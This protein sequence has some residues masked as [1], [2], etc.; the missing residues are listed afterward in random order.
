MNKNKIVVCFLVMA[1]FIVTFGVVMAANPKI[2]AL[3]KACES[4][5]QKACDDLC[6]LAP[7]YCPTSGGSVSVVVILPEDNIGEYYIDEN[8]TRQYV[9]YKSWNECMN[10][11]GDA[12]KCGTIVTDACQSCLGTC[13]AAGS[14]ASC[15]AECKNSCKDNGSKTAGGSDLP[16][17][18]D[19][20]GSYYYE[21]G[22]KKYSRFNGFASC[23]T[24]MGDASYCVNTYGYG[25]GFAEGFY[26]SL[27]CSPNDSEC[28]NRIGNE[29]A[30]ACK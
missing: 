1:I 29:Y 11:F 6:A 23:W 21:N 15:N 2:D 5:N 17:G 7:E 4:G 10:V 25:C 24:L 30:A 14:S 22:L 28:V 16:A 8:G 26:S 20:F 12:G 27:L 3:I 18:E 13:Q 9:S 19:D